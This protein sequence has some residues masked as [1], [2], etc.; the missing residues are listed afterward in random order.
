MLVRVE[1]HLYIK[2]EEQRN[3]RGRSKS[4]YL[5]RNK[6]VGVCMFFRAVLLLGR[7][8]S[9]KARAK[10]KQYTNGLTDIL[11]GLYP[12]GSS[13]TMMGQKIGMM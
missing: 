10:S 6:C 12:V 7:V 8:V 11:H 1:M 9:G 4:N 5:K 3:C 2:T 13:I